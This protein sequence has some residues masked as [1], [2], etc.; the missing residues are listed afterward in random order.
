MLV[1]VLDEGARGYVLGNYAASTVVLV[2]LWVLA[3]REHVGLDP[4]RPRTAR[5]AAALRRRRRCRPTRRSSL[6]NV[7]DR[8]YLL[9]VE[10]AAAAG[11]YSVAVKLA[12]ARDR[13][14]PR[15]PARVAAAGLLDHRRRRGGPRS[16]RCVTT[17]YV[18]V[19]GAR[20]RRAST[21][22]GRWVVRLLDRAR[23][24]P[25]ATRRCPGSRWAGRC[26]GSSCCS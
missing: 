26:T 7:V 18:I 6:L 21:L 13:R 15:L 2:G 11:L 14:R 20:R 24:L 10:I 17:A 23:V 12:T 25:R 22:L 19:T 16:T 1:V 3:L 8:A 5:A 9:R 4:G